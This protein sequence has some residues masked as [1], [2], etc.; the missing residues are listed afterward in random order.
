[1]PK[2][3]RVDLKVLWGNYLGCLQVYKENVGESFLEWP[4]ENT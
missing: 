1:M 2:H 4:F 3:L